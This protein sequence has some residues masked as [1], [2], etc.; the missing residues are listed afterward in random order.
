MFHDLER[1]LA[2]REA[3]A[4]L[5]GV[6]RR[7]H[8]SD[9]PIVVLVYQGEGGHEQLVDDFVLAGP[10]PYFFMV[11]AGTYRLAAFEDLNQNF[12]YNPEVDPAAL[13]HAGAP[14]TVPA[15]ATVEGL[16]IGIPDAGRE[17]IPVAFSSADSQGA[18]EKLLTDFHAGEVTRIDDPRFSEENA[19][20][21]LWEPSEF[22]LEVGAGVYFLEPYDPRKLP[23]LF[24]HGALGHPGNWTRLI[25]ALDR[26][27][28]QPWLA[29]YPTAVRLDMTIMSL[30]RWMQRLYVRYRYPRLAIVGHSMG[31]LVAR[32]FV[33]RVATAG[34]G[35]VAGLR[36]LVTLST[37]WDGQVGAQIGVATAPVVAPSWYDMA[38]GS[39]FLRTLLGPELPPTLVH[40]LLY[41]SAGGTP[42][43]RD[44]NDGS[45]TVASQLLPRARSRARLVQGFNESHTTILESPD[46]A[47]LINEQLASVGGHVGGPS[48]LSGFQ[49]AVRG[50]RQASGG[51]PARERVAAG[52]PKG[53]EAGGNDR[54]GGRLPSA[55]EVE[56]LAAG[57]QPE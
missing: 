49:V 28:F 31:G 10:G 36:L 12:A 53:I 38:P 20:R 4:V 15:G 24:L 56:G 21:G 34:D 44:P 1:N 46:V 27:R 2:Q 40:D 54:E 55:R 48:P 43:L 3:Y 35:R 23:V 8:A 33:N 32:G 22:L 18:G 45:V 51:A 9:R 26:D 6:V 16:D 30:D 29:Y 37:P 52:S 17:R 13:L 57:R 7:E 14:V 19:H 5:R 11:R 42:L 47:A 50:V 41:S 39:P 25:S